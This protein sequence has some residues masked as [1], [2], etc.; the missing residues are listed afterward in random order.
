[1]P[2]D[3]VNKADGN[4]EIS[5]FGPIA[6][7]KWFDDE[8]TPADIRD[9]LNTMKG[10]KRV[11]LY[12]NSPGGG[13]FAGFTIYNMI[14]QFSGDIYAHVQ[15][16]AASIA[17]VIIM[18]AKEISIPKNGMVMIHRAQGMA[19]GTAEEML[20]T[21]ALLEKIEGNIAE[22]YADRT[23]V[24][25]QKALDMMNAETWMTG[26]EAVELGFADVLED[27]IE[28]TA[29]ADKAIINGQEVSFDTFKTFPK[30]KIETFANKKPIIVVP[31]NYSYFENAIEYT[32][33]TQKEVL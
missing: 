4:G 16:L 27:E 7:M 12:V 30:N 6:D 26:A 5:I 13:V 14:K 20:K 31:Q 21:A 18:A 8:T 15:G 2:I 9:K 3:I 11:D 28:L 25:K 29:C 24:D 17:S 23:K 22:T 19:F 32:N 1:M 10:A 33:L